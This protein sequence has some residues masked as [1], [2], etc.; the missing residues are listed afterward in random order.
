MKSISKNLNDGVINISETPF[1]NL[2][3]NNLLIRNHFS[4]ISTGTEGKTISDARKNL[5]SK[6]KSRQKEVQKVIDMIKSNGLINTYKFVMNKLNTPSALGYSSVGEVIALGGN[7]SSFSVGDFVACGGS[8]ANHADVISVPKNL[9]VKVEE[10]I[11]LKQAAFTTLGSIVIQGIRRSKLV[12]G[13]SALI[14]GLGLLGQLTIKILNSIGVKTIGVDINDKNIKYAKKIGLKNIFNRNQ[15]SLDKVIYELSDGHGVDSVII[16]AGTKSSDP[17][18]FAGRVSRKKG[19][20]VIVGDVSPNF[21][22]ENFYKKELDLLMSMSYGPGRY[23]I[24][25]EDKGLDYPIEYVRFTQNR[26]MKSFLDLLNNNLSIKDLITH[27]YNLLDAGEAY[28]TIL[29]KNQF[30]LGMVIKYDISKK[31]KKDVHF[32]NNYNKSKSNINISFIG[33]GNF[34]KSMLL[35]NLENKCKFISVFNNSGISSSH[36]ARKYKFENIYSD[37]QSI[38]KEKN[39]I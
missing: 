23:D 29:D 10:N 5:L 2:S 7:V 34:A 31:I 27:E 30:A 28:N 4:I 35:P 21:A 37:S 32:K 25:Y 15:L 24:N 1:P 39:Q 12:F 16:T 18:N 33:A 20:I 38:F 22:R 19:K 17:I 14:I 9:C 8:S 6:A 26:N 3:K 36:V 13:N 11:D